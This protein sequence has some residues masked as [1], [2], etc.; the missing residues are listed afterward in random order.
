MD[1]EKQQLAIAEA[2][3]WTE[4]ERTRD[5]V[6][7]SARFRFIA[8][9]PASFADCKR[10]LPD[11]PNDL[12]AIHAVAHKRFTPA[13]RNEVRFWLYKICGGGFSH[14]ATAQQFCE[15]CLRVLGKW[16]E[17]DAGRGELLNR[18]K[19]REQRKPKE[20]E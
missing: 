14:M 1:A 12:N 3:G 9:A 8:M 18:S 6:C 15:A 11:F 5:Y 20:E 16:E 13:Q 17:E 19:Q 4:I 10:Y 2:A 7:A